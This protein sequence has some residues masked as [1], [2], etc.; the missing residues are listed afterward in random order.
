MSRPAKF[1][2][3]LR[4]ALESLRGVVDPDATLA[5]LLLKL[6]SAWHARKL[7]EYRS[8]YEGNEIRVDRAMSRERF[9]V[10]YECTFQRL[11]ADR[12]ADNLGEKI[13]SVLR[14]LELVNPR[15]LEGVFGSIDFNSTELGTAEQ[16]NARL[17]TLL[18]TLNDL[19]ID[20]TVQTAS[21][22]PLHTLDTLKGLA[23]WSEE[24]ISRDT[25]TP[26]PLP[27]REVAL[28]MTR[29][30]VP[31][32]GERIYDLCCGTGG[33]LIHAAREV[34]SD[35][36]ALFGH[37]PRHR[38]WATGKMNLILAALDSADIRQSD[39][40]RNPIVDKEDHLHKFDVVISIPPFALEDWGA[41]SVTHDR[42]K[43][44][45]RGIPPK[46]SGDYA[47]ITHAV[48]TMQE[49]A[50]RAGLILPL[51]VLFRGGTEGLIRRRLIEENRL[52]GVIR[53]PTNIL[54]GTP[55]PVV[56]L[57]FKARKHDTSVLFIDAS[58]DFLNEKNRNRLRNSDIDKIVSVWES[59]ADIPGYSRRVSFDEIQGNDFN[60]NV[61][62][63]IKGAD[64]K[65]IDLAEAV[66]RIQ[67]LEQS[68][69]EARSR[70]MAALE[71]LP[72]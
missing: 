42:L 63:Y 24:P 40:I 69:G 60:L 59:K 68:W 10:P 14:Q 58:T 67:T 12:D 53:L 16:R 9:I 15:K 32:S 35:N 54:L 25:S 57:M 3:S 37:E 47:F 43:R 56:L 17:R 51:G 44:F 29:L 50:G 5:L 34:G 31:T 7:E 64:E 66:A 39:P 20:L 41:E 65:S 1:E 19:E 11:F 28:L 21:G 48:E 6:L 55:L 49:Q 13:N 38:L 70:L 30:V 4:E 52:D 36:F 26:T 46:S 2:Q 22:S 72:Q 61:P 33:L 27:P 71:R 23:H 62:L 45:H 18:T 8:K